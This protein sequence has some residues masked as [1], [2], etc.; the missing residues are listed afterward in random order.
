MSCVLT[1]IIVKKNQIDFNIKT[2]LN[3]D[4]L[5]D[6]KWICSKEDLEV[7]QK[8]RINLNWIKEEIF[9]KLENPIERIYNGDEY[10][11]DSYLTKKSFIGMIVRKES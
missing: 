3:I 9:N 4:D 10:S 8:I 7:V 11:I 5:K 2:A 6:V 1:N